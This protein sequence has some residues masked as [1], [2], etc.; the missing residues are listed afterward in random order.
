MQPQINAIKI[1]HPPYYCSS[2]TPPSAATAADHAQ[3][4]ASFS[5]FQNLYVSPLFLVDAR[6]HAVPR[7]S[8][9]SCGPTRGVA[10]SRG[11]RIEVAHRDAS[12]TRRVEKPRAYT[13]II[14]ADV[15]GDAK[16]REFMQR[17]S[18]RHE[19]T[20]SFVR[21]IATRNALQTVA[22]RGVTARCTSTRYSPTAVARRPAQ[23]LFTGR[24]L[25][26]RDFTIFL[27]FF[28]APTKIKPFEDA[29]YYAESRSTTVARRSACT[30][31]ARR[32]LPQS[33]LLADDSLLSYFLDIP[34]VSLPFMLRVSWNP[35]FVTSFILRD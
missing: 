34:S 33:I 9:C 30:G 14:D 13:I 25:R 24:R 15:C 22:E 6:C 8:P 7:E 12:V 31:G 27:S 10:T 16:R 29:R 23:T 32:P 5:E 26:N 35:C 20:R 11:P 2:Y 17:D 21:D 28:R 1:E 19:L 18:K 4:A 3:P